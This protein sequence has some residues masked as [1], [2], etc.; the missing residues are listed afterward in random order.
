MGKREH[1][2]G[3]SNKLNRAI[4][5]E[6]VSLKAKIFMRERLINQSKRVPKR[7]KNLGI[8]LLMKV[9]LKILLMNQI[10]LLIPK[11]EDQ[12]IIAL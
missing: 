12:R 10:N 7:I 6:N 4:I 8:S 11:E 1:R 5:K 3:R 2:W 9:S